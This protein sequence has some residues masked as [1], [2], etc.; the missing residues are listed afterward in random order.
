MEEGEGIGAA[1][2][3]MAVF[4]DG[5]D[6]RPAK[7]G[8]V[9][10]ELVDRPVEIA[11]GER[12]T[13]GWQSPVA[14]LARSIGDRASGLVLLG[15][16]TADFR[17]I[18]VLDDLPAL[19][20]ITH[21]DVMPAPQAVWTK[22]RFG[23]IDLVPVSAACDPVRSIDDGEHEAAVFIDLPVR[24]AVVVAVGEEQGVVFFVDA[25]DFDPAT[26]GEG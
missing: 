14:Q 25:I 11:D 5:L 6:F 19:I 24:F 1:S 18:E 13:L 3:G 26:E 8:G 4:K 17:S 9:D 2:F 10:G 23:E 21:R 12:M 16:F 22:D 7:H 20:V 15:N